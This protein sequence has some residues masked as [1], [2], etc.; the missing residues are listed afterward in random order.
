MS[1]ENF[2]EAVLQSRVPVVV[3]W[4]SSTH[5]ES[6]ITRL[7]LTQAL[8]Q[9][10]KLVSVDIEANVELTMRYSIR[11]M[12]Y[13]MLFIDGFAVVADNDLELFLVGIKKWIA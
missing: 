6:N 12:P 7:R 8:S 5:A 4:G 2:D 9:T 13:M 11:F 10:Q 3:F 1:N